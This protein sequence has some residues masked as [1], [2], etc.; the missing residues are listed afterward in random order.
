MSFPRR[1]CLFMSAALAA[2]GFRRQRQENVFDFIIVGAGSSGCVLANR[3]S[4]NPQN[5]VLL[6]EAGGPEADPLIQVPG[7]W[8]SLLGSALDCN[9][10]TLMKR[11][12]GG[13]A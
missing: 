3:L 10:P 9:S 5:R 2:S 12:L 6:V 1:T 8:T 13:R 7:K 11:G 4:A